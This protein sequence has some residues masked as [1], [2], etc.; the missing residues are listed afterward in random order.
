MHGKWLDKKVREYLEQYDSEPLYL[1]L[2]GSRMKDMHSPESDFDVKC[3]YIKPLESYLTLDM[4]RKDT[5]PETTFFGYGEEYNVSF[6]DISKFLHMV[7][8]SNL[9]A[10]EML[11]PHFVT[12]AHMLVNLWHYRTRYFGTKEL[13]YQSSRQSH[14][15]L[16]RFYVESIET[17]T[18]TLAASVYAMLQ[19]INF[20]NYGSCFYPTVYTDL[21]FLADVQYKSRMTELFYAKKNNIVFN[22]TADFLDYL[23]VMNHSFKVFD[24]SK[25]SVVDTKEELDKLF[26]DV[27]THN[28]LV[29]DY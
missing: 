22:P 2:V 12:C 25:L 6:I 14:N 28:A 7:S 26:F 4:K 9:T 18:K 8:K 17:Q 5:L 13:F 29:F 3:A 19:A 16:N 21:I 23:E 15:L 10:F 24:T 11:S 27:V 1:S 20:Q